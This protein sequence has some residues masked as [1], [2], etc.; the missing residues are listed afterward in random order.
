[1]SLLVPVLLVLAPALTPPLWHTTPH[2]T[3]SFP[4]VGAAAAAAEEEA[5]AA[6]AAGEAGGGGGGW[7]RRSL[8]VMCSVVCVLTGRCLRGPL[9]RCRHQL[10]RHDTAWHRPLLRRRFACWM[11][12][13]LR[14]S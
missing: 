12:D 13:D 14:F 2:W 3:T 9:R 11:Y 4:L 8:F 10:L 6:A 7:H 5:E 1:M